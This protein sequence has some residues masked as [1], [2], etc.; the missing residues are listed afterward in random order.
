[1]RILIIEDQKDKLSVLQTE[2]QERLKNHRHE[3]IHADS[4]SIASKYIY[5]KKFELIIIDLMMPVRQGGQPEDISDE[6]ISTIELSDLNK[7]AHVIALSGF[8]DLVAE[9]R[10]KYTDANIILIYYDRQDDS[11][12][13]SLSLAIDRIR[14]ETIFDFVIIC[15]L[16]KE[17]NAYRSTDA[18]VGEYK[19]IRGLDCLL[20]NIGELR[21][22]CVK[23]P[24]MGLVDA[25]IISSR[26]IERFSPRI[27]AISG[28]C[29]GCAK[30]EIGT[31]I[32]ADPC[33][34]Y[35]AG[36]WA[37]DG[38][39]IEHYDVGLEV[40]VK[41]VLSQL[42]DQSSNGAQYKKDLPV[43][44]TVDEKIIIAPIASGSAVIASQP[45]LAQIEEQHRK[46]AGL[47]MEMYG[48]YKSAQLSAVN[49]IFFGAKT[50]V[51]LAHSAKGDQYHEYGAILS[52][53]FVID[54]IKKLHTDLVD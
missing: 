13:K 2:L 9:Q 20:L 43:D 3:I 15:A 29:A 4:L 49:P 18:Q 35:Q 51:D 38:F 19:N 45:R 44:P 48:L 7:G 26:A 28:I 39:K 23:L 34:E 21:G 53:R 6:I 32:V 12:K 24:R 41:T 10:T 25:S 14:K 1:M 52:A 33:W 17:R 50:V 36:K 22:V 42:I 40:N 5:E 8:E 47:D 31:L 54:A 30:S 37:D 16:D 27:I 11:W 46:I